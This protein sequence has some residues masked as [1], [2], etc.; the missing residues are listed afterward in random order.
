MDLVILLQCPDLAP[1]ALVLCSVPC[2][3][4]DCYIG[5][6]TVLLTNYEG[7]KTCQGAMVLGRVRIYHLFGDVA[8]PTPSLSP[9]PS[10]QLKVDLTVYPE[11]A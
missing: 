10:L 6:V 4:K 9:F 11:K 5:M 8:R 1:W 2:P 3:R 7:E